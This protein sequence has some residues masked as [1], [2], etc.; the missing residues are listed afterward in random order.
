VLAAITVIGLPFAIAA[1]RIAGF[2]LI[3]FGRRL[4]VAEEIGERRIAGTGIASFL[5]IV[6]AGWWLSLLHLVW[7]IFH[8]IT[9]IG[10]PFGLAHF[11]LA[12]ICLSPLGKRNVSVDMPRLG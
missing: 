7:G 1:F 8:C 6:L 12:S 5:W 11:K 3:P 2:S 4:A 9:I 10:I